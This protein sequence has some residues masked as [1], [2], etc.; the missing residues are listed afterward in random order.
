MSTAPLHPIALLA[1]LRV[2]LNTQY[3]SAWSKAHAGK[4]SELVDRLASSTSSGSTDTSNTNRDPRG[5]V[6][7]DQDSIIAQLGKLAQT[8][9]LSE[10]N[11]GGPL[12][13]VNWTGPSVWTDAVLTYLKARYGLEWTDLR[14]LREPLRV[15]D[16][17]ILPVT[18][19]SPGVGNFGAGTVH[20][21]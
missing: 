10:P 1:L 4:I 9:V 12:G 19:F 6:T 14:G 5:D 7:I 21:E 16:V 8:T 17:V 20:G 15:G 2:A 11:Q 18:G 3:A 13:V